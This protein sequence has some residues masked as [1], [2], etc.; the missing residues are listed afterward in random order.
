M[1]IWHFGVFRIGNNIDVEELELQ[2]LIESVVE[3]L[4]RFLFLLLGGEIFLGVKYLWRYW[5]QYRYGGV[6]LQ[7]LIESVAR[8]L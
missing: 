1:C 3:Q 5:K 8:Q 7:L 2:F 6:V 4:K